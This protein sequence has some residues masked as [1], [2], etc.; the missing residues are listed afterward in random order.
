MRYQS[1]HYIS[2]CIIKC[3]KSRYR[4]LWKSQ[5]THFQVFSQKK[6]KKKKDFGVNDAI[7]TIVTKWDL[8]VFGECIVFIHNQNFFKYAA[9]PFKCNTNF[10]K[11]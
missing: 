10:G 5:Y 11:Y 1:P 6:K 9:F 4:K 8:I 2:A 3:Q 7:G